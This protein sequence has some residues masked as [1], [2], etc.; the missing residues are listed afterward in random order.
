MDVFAH[1]PM[2]ARSLERPQ[3]AQ[4]GARIRSVS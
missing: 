4:P 3:P 2:H 1:E